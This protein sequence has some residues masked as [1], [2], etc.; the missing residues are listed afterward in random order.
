M[1]PCN[2]SH[3]PAQVRLARMV[4][5]DDGAA[6]AREQTLVVP[7]RPFLLPALAKREPVKLWWPPLLRRWGS[8]Q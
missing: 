3:T 7:V 8:P 4:T 1:H 2:S 5:L 6:V